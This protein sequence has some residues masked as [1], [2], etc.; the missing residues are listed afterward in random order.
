M[1]GYRIIIFLR[2]VESSVF[3]FNRRVG[4]RQ[5]F[6]WATPFPRTIKTDFNGRD[7]F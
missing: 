7:S 3:D 4:G 6:H 5:F 1:V 2:V